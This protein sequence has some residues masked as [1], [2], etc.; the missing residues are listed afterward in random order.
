[1]YVICRMSFQSTTGYYIVHVRTYTFK[2]FEVQKLYADFRLLGVSVLIALFE[3][4]LYSTLHVFFFNVTCI[5][6][7]FVSILHKYIK[8][9]SLFMRIHSLDSVK[10]RSRRNL[11]LNIFNAVIKY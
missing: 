6:C 3:G 8:I 2:L 5:P 11:K 1:M 4:Q 7:T 9:R 10:S